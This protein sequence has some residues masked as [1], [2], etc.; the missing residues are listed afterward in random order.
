MKSEAAEPE[1]GHQEKQK[2]QLQHHEEPVSRISFWGR[3]RKSLK[4]EGGENQV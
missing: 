4:R 2:Q 1:S 3:T